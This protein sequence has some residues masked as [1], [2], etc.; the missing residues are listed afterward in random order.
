VGEPVGLATADRRRRAGDALEAIWAGVRHPGQA[1]VG[2]HE[3]IQ[4]RAAR[5]PDLV[6]VE[7]GNRQLRYGELN[8]LANR[9]AS[10]LRR[11]QVG[12]GGLVGIHLDPSVELVVA[13]LA[14]LKAGAA[15]VPLDPG[16]PRDRLGFMVADA[17]ARV[18]LTG[19]SDRPPAG[20]AKTVA[21]DPDWGWLAGE[22]DHD[23]TIGVAAGHPA[24]VIYTSGST[25]RPKGVCCHHLGAV[26]L[27]ADFIGRRP[28]EL[29]AP[30]SFWT[31]FSFDVAVYEI[32]SALLGGTLV[33]VPA[34]ARPSARDFLGLL[35]AGRVQAA[36]I[37][38]FML[39]DTAEWAAANPG[40]LALRRLLVGVEPIPEPLLATLQQRIA[41]LHVI[42]GYGPTE[43][44]VCAT[45]Y[46]LPS[47]K[48]RGA[49]A[50]NR[51]T[52]IGRPLAGGTAH[53]LDER[54]MAVA[55]G[56][57]GEL[58][59]GG[60]GVAHGYHRR[61]GLT[62][63]R[64]LPDPFAGTPGARMYR[65]GDLVRLLPDGDLVFI[66]RADHQV[67][68]RGHRVEL[69]EVEAVLAAHEEV[70][71]AAVVAREDPSVGLQL[72]AYVVPQAP[73]GSDAPVGDRLRRHLLD[74]LPAHMVPSVLVE[75][76]A[77][78]LTPTGKLD[79]RVL[80]APDRR[81]P[82][83][84]GDGGPPR[85]PAERA[86]A[87][88]WSEALGIDVGDI[89]RD[90]DFYALGGHSLLAV[91][92]AARARQT[93]GVEIPVR[94]LLQRPRLD[95]LAAALEGC[96]AGPAGGALARRIGGGVAPLS[97]PQ[98]VLWLFHQLFEGSTAYNVP[99]V[100]RLDGRLDVAALRRSLN[101]VVRRHE[102]LRTTIA[103]RDG[104]PIQ[105]V[106][107]ALD[108]P[109][110][111]TDLR[112]VTAAE[113]QA[114]A[115]RM[116]ETEV[117]RPF[118]LRN[119]PL[120]R[121]RLLRLALDRHVLVLTLHHLVTDGWSMELLYRELGHG[122][123]TGPGSTAPPLPD[124][125]VRYGDFAAW[126]RS[127]EQDDVRRAELGY[128][129][130]QL[131]GEL[132]TP[133][134]PTSRPRP[135]T[136]TF[137]GE[138]CTLTLP[139]GLC[140]ALRGLC[141]QE[142]VTLF[143]AL[144]AAFKLVLARYSGHSEVVVGTPV[145]GRD[146]LEVEQLVGFFNNT[147]VLRTDLSGAPSF[148]ELLGRVHQVVVDALAHRKVPFELLVR[149]L[150]P[151]RD[152][153]RNPLFQVWFNMLSYQTNPLSLAGLRVEQLEPPVAGAL[154]DLSLYVVDRGTDIRLELVYDTGLF[155]RDR[156]L[157]LLEQL[158]QL[159]D[160]AVEQPDRGV[161]RYSLMTP[162]ARRAIRPPRPFPEPVSGTVAQRLREQAVRHPARPAV[163]HG[164][165]VWTYGELEA[166]AGRLAGR[167]RASGVGPGD[168]A[169]IVA[170]RT[171]TLVQAILGVLK[172]GAAFAILDASQ[173]PSRLQRMA[174]LARPRAW[175][176]AG[177]TAPLPPG[178]AELADAGTV[179]CRIR[180][181]DRDR[182]VERL[183]QADPGPSPAEDTLAYLAFTSGSTGRPRGV[184]G[185]QRPLLAFLDW[186]T[187]AFRLD[188]DDRFSMLSGLSHDPLLRDVLAPLWLGATLCVPEEP[189]ASSPQ[190]LL[191]WLA[192]ERIT[193]AHLTP[194]MSRLL[195]AA[196]EASPGLLPDLRH[197]GSG[198]D[199][200]TTLDAR[201]LRRLAPRARLINL[202]GT[203]ETPQ[204]V[205]FFPVDR[206]EDAAA[207]PIGSGTPNA[208]LL[209]LRPGLEEA[210]V[211]ELG[212]IGVRSPYLAE[213]YLGDEPATLER[214]LPDPFHRQAG[215]RLYLTGD[216][217]RLRPDGQVEFVGRRD[218]QVKIRGF[219]IELAEVEASLREH[220]EVRDCA[221]LA[222]GD[223]GV[224]RRLHAYAVLRRP[225]SPEALLQDLRRWMPQQMLPSVVT[226]L[227]RLPLT[228][229]GKL[230]VKTLPG[231]VAAAA[232]PSAKP[233]E[234]TVM[235]IWKGVLGVDAVAPGDNFFDLGGTSLAMVQVHDAL[236]RATGQT[237][238]I[239]MLFRHPNARTLAAAMT[240]EAAAVTAISKGRTD[241]T[242]V[243]RRRL[244]ART[245]ARRQ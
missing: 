85:T 182:P 68:I 116:V 4:A 190:R 172:A 164:G 89:R 36:Y 232:R 34:E 185:G 121:A 14:V 98:Q 192:E 55:P 27:L 167:L 86:L 93:L 112:G 119:G 157:V 52:P 47:M 31:S 194:L 176:E 38:P 229:N 165:L 196:P 213:G 33:V 96:T 57:P 147:L 159:L 73:A 77:L 71:Q 82:A 239:V 134:L 222:I 115:H 83:A 179:A 130:R 209:V 79:R 113:R 13:V 166:A 216:M 184:L 74:R 210:A 46:S 120:L 16:Y 101:A 218:R 243:R 245:A 29:G 105:R 223:D 19:R 197:V 150:R 12:P 205:S 152:P 40:A 141:R 75:L 84:T 30:C 59:V 127:P 26:N 202:Y 61:P 180:L 177:P 151:N 7:L 187:A 56:E 171:A 208:E 62:A 108:V 94:T 236:Q 241:P 102:A 162:D 186:Y 142:R 220:P 81:P 118:D 70:R 17:R 207:V 76:D 78:P 49:P 178:L 158:R 50:P 10:R 42:N 97:F 124:P 2:L 203:T 48:G 54:L 244:A 87:E 15:Y 131:A 80:P 1:A 237:I 143:T 122:Y 173:P 107:A 123:R 69:G 149:E 28:L 8:A 99:A 132:A 126:Q 140:E 189:I 240:S 91:R 111:V 201:R 206:L 6:A 109:L 224:E 227:D 58:F 183:P 3:L 154:F 225:L 5:D 234:R 45:A 155:D 104:E 231:P 215:V 65:T 160:A 106:A 219:R 175:I 238:P 144:L 226:L 25:G 114:A 95:A 129:R 41:G 128:W 43:T 21:L 125:P 11:L 146:H 136:P 117:R 51:R 156:M 214:F 161:E 90:H 181:P 230:D 66:G 135:P 20:A 137:A 92:I 204:A 145:A 148:R 23:P 174:E 233:L 22:P 18:V 198:G 44:H 110:P 100:F 211:N 72:V 200:L 64:F 88:L 39:S 199:L 138:R 24:Y 193:V 32:F 35:A 242:E 60:I 170:G 67:K 37:P 103:V 228:A 163:R 139:A 188:A 9:L 191:R 53:V 217:G 195:D 168:V 133:A 63:E 153:S 212:E 235:D 169:A 221:V